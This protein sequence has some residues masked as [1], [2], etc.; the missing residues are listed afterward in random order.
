MTDILRGSGYCKYCKCKTNQQF[1]P[2]DEY[3]IVRCDECKNEWKVPVVY[4]DA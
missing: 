3:A 2:F 1:A 4:D